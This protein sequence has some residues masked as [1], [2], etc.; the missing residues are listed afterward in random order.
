MSL[1]IL[2]GIF[3]DDSVWTIPPAQIERLRARFPDE[4]FSGAWTR[5]DIL[6]KVADIDVAFSPY[7]TP[8]ALARA[9]RLKW[10][11]SSA[12][13]VGSLL[14]PEMV[15]SNVIVTN[16]R[17]VHATPMAEHVLT[18]MLALARKLPL[19][20]RRQRERRWAQQEVYEGAPP[21]YTLRGRRLGVIGLGAIG[22]EV[23]RLALAVGMRVS[24][25]RRRVDAPHPEGLDR[26]YAPDQLHL[27]LAESHIVVVAVPLT[28]DTRGLIGAR[29]LRT[30]QPSAFLI[31]VGRG[32]VIDEPALAEELAK[33]TIAGAALDVVAHEP[34]DPE[35][36]LW[37][38][39]NVLITP[40]VSTARH[41]FW[42]AVVDLFADNLTRY[43]A[44]Q[45]L[46]NV[47]DKRAGY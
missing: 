32:K 27:L 44:G 5:D 26:V 13:G 33:G 38:L 23:A 37:S 8:A 19:A 17:G 39:D 28:R 7:I 22:S 2:V 30:M 4:V 45:P 25:V 1:H 43:R 46:N 6:E 34:L 40:H 15:A 12:T 10:V 18:L 11:H 16:S 14:T 29:E 41:D 3:D 35:S 21:V 31:N 42:D 20:V 9:P 24:A 36:P 47:V